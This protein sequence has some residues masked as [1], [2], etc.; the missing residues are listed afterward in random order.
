V[1]RWRIVVVLVL[2]A[3]PVSLLSGLGLYFSW[4]QGWSIWLWWPLSGCLA[5]AYLLA[6]R[7]QRSMRLIGRPDFDLPL[8]WTEQDQR[9]WRIVTQRAETKVDPRR[10]GDLTFYAET[11]RELAEEITRFYHP[12]TTDPV[13]ALTIPEILAVVELAAHD[14]AELVD[15]YLPGGHLLT[16]DQWRH[17]RQTANLYSKASRLYWMVSALFNPV[18]SGVKFAASQLGLSKPWQMLQDDLLLWFYTAYLQRVGAYLIDLNS[19]RL[20]VGASRYR[21]LVQ[22]K[23]TPPE[24]GV[25]PAP[26]VTL[27][28]L[29]QVKAGKS[30]VINALLGEQRAQTDVLPA[31]SGNAHY[32]LQ[33]AEVDSRLVLID[34][35]GYGH[36]GPSADQIEV[37]AEAARASDLLLLVMHARNPARQPDVE[38]LRALEDWF[39]R[40]PERKMPPVLG[41]LTHIDLLSPALE[42]SPP[43]DWQDPSRPKEQQIQQALT[44]VRDQLG[45]HLAGCV[46]LCAAAG[47]VYGVE[48]W[49]M[50]TLL[51]LLEEARAVGLLRCLHAE[52]DAGKAR[53]L[54]SQMLA[55]GGTVLRHLLEKA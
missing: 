28:V 24:P 19:G 32:Q 31:T 40:R 53:K 29:G 54:L 45:S 1:S 41:V 23:Q 22:S 8:A 48:E 15:Q 44:A 33:P 47:R 14:M 6:L 52:A 4:Q 43:Y 13:G 10:L 21:T 34:T 7:W 50:P 38:L 25:P 55:A 3:L 36:A 46:P 49:L 39:A 35:V 26:L 9:A 11:A 27:T 30:S 20:R 12:K 5:L 18:E 37:T 2:V 17:A 42:W 16:V 51:Q